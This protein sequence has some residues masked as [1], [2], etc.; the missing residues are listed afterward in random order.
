MVRHVLRYFVYA[1]RKETGQKTDLSATDH[2]VMFYSEFWR[3]PKSKRKT[4]DVKDDVIQ[5]E[6]I[7]NKI[8]TTN[9]THILQ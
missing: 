5:P 2:C 3:I 4:I 9:L 6:M 8:K 1:L 7:S